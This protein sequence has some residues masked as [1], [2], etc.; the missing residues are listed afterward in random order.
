MSSDSEV[1]KYR[2]PKNARPLL[3]DLYLYPDLSTGLFKGRITLSQA[4]Q[5]YRVSF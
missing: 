4:Y 5:L 2:L 3:Y 1:S